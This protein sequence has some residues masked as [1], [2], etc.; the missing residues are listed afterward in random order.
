[1]AF[2]YKIYTQGGMHV[3]GTLSDGTLIGERTF[4]PGRLEAQANIIK[5]N[6]INLVDSITDDII[7]DGVSNTDLLTDKGTTWGPA[8]NNSVAALNEFF[9]TAVYN[10]TQLEGIPTPGDTGYLKWTGSAYEWAPITGSSPAGYITALQDDDSPVLGGN[11]TVNGYTVGINE[12]VE[13]SNNLKLTSRTTAPTANAGG[14]YYN[15]SSDAF[16]VALES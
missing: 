8:V 11:L 14:M 3:L 2:T 10:I 7:L 16:F 9:Q 4:N 6:S 1:M 12:T 13:I 5:F 15:S